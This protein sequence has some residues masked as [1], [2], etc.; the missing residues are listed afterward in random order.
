M[1]LIITTSCHDI[2]SLSFGTFPQVLHI[3][4]YGSRYASLP[5]K[6]LYKIS[7]Q[8]DEEEDDVVIHPFID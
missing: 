5:E 2:S 1:K 4:V 3:I 6:L 7:L 8:Q